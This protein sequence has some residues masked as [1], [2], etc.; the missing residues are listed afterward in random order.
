MTSLTSTEL[1]QIR[2][3]IDDLLPD[4]CDILSVTQVSDGAGGI[5]DTW[6]TL[7]ASVPCRLDFSNPG[8]ESQANA[9]YTAFK[10][11]MLSVPY[12]TVVTTANRISK[13]GETY[14]VKG[15][16]N[17]QSWIGVKRLS[18]ERVP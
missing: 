17:A 12:D 18:V 10:M 5:T 4:E 8:K 11:G 16:N 1:A 14:D 3:A 7:S 6:G 9:S 13:D 15:V 2:E